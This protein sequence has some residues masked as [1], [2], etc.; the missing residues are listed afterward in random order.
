VVQFPLSFIQT[1]YL[2]PEKSFLKTDRPSGWRALMSTDGH[3][4][5]F[6][7][8][9]KSGEVTRIMFSRT[10]MSWYALVANNDSRQIPSL[11]TK[12]TFK[13]DSVIRR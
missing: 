13:V 3:Y 1:D 4:H 8:D 11:A 9:L 2:N 7:Y 5:Q 6:H 12:N 10:N